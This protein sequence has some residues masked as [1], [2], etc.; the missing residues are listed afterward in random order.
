MSA[1]TRIVVATLLA[2]ALLPMSALADS[3][4]V[5][6]PSA[7]TSTSPE[8]TATPAPT[9]TPVPDSQRR[10]V[11]GR[12]E[13]SVSNG[14]KQ[15]DR[16]DDRNVRTGVA[17]KAGDTVTI[18]WAEKVN[19]GAV[20]WEWRLGDA[21]V[22]T[23]LTF[24]DE[25]DALLGTLE[26]PR[27]MTNNLEYLPEGTRCVR[28]TA[29]EDC[30]IAELRMYRVN[31]VPAAVPHFEA[32][33]TKADLLLVAAHP[34]DEPVLLG[35]IV[36][37]YDA[38][39][40]LAVQVAALTDGES[41]E[42]WIGRVYE[43]QRGLSANKLTHFPLI[44]GLSDKWS[45]NLQDA[46]AI[47]ETRGQ[48]ALGALVG[49]IR[50]VKPQVIVTHDLNGEYGHGAHMA[51]AHLM[52]RA[53]EQAADPACYPES[54]DAF[55][56]WQAKKLY[57]HLYPENKVL[58]DVEA[59]LDAFDG[60]TALEMALIGLD[61][62]RSQLGPTWINM[63]S[64]REYD[65]ADYGLYFSTVGYDESGTD[66]FDNIDPSCLSNYVE[67]EPTPT[68]VPAPTSAPTP[69]PDPKPTQTVPPE[70]AEPADTSATSRWEALLPV[71]ALLI[72]ATGALAVAAIRGKWFGGRKK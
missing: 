49:L 55:G 51:T 29:V 5:T 8:P 41:R 52:T 20:Y 50:R 35:G 53:V 14:D 69:P 27:D 72:A 30:R 1:A 60:K 10:P 26:R 63:L 66:F 23:K 40:G 4:P 61:Y 12:C 18:R 24:L 46:L 9:A 25:N 54:A 34:D 62:Q 48:D 59:P 19:C 13:V 39:R 11:N 3:T 36:P 58:L 57:L 31:A 22:G 71:A 16:L 32:P 17:L 42:E 47:W 67:P 45:N 38:E 28:L 21:P 6:V 56:I 37:I 44:L 7:V 15:T 65:I 70:S 68:P 33:L 2:A 64:R 43:F